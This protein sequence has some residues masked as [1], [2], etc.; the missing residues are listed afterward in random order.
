MNS[1]LRTAARFFRVVAEPQAYLNLVYLLV[2]FP[3]GVAYF[4][5]LVTGLS[6]GISLLIV[7]VG[8]PILLLMG[9]ITW[10]L[11]GFE[12]LMAVHLLKESFP[13]HATQSTVGNS[14]WAGLKRHVTDPVTWQGLLY[15][16]MKFPLGIA[17]FVVLTTLL[18]LTIS[19]LAMPFLYEFVPGLQAGVNL[20][21]G[22]PS[23]QIDSLG[24][25]LLVAL[26]GLGLWPV[27]MHVTNGMAWLYGRFARVM[28][29]D[30]LPVV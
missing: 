13:A 12:R 10:G 2:A 28:L 27:T 5:L 1:T 11:A 16:L 30:G 18:A 14:I 25:A 6:S 21:P 8:I 24:D 4:V 9:A 7:W 17:A 23:W 26:V 29:S 19:L 15:L 22:L 20:G 3:L